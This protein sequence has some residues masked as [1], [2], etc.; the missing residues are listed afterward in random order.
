MANTSFTV[1]IRGI[2]ENPA[3][4]EVN[5]RS[6]PNTNYALLFKSRVGTR[7]LPVLEVRADD[8]NANL[9]GKTYQWLHCAFPNGQTDRKSV[10]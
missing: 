2:P 4:V 3:V 10:V 6:G 8:Q 1:N 7:G 9:R 5:V